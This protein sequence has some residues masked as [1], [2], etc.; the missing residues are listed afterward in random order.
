MNISFVFLYIYF[1]F[2]DKPYL[3]LQLLNQKPKESTHAPCAGVGLILR[4]AFPTMWGDTWNELV[5]VLPAP[6]S[7]RSAS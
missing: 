1:N 6:V 3:V 5:E 4:L 7:P 2:Y